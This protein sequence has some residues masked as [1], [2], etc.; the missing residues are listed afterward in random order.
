MIDPSEKGRYFSWLDLNSQKKTNLYFP[1]TLQFLDFPHIR[2]DFIPMAI[3][4]LFRYH[5]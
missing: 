5:I 3:E 2:D 1:L 4:T